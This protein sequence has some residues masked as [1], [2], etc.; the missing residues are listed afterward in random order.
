[1]EAAV[2]KL[3]PLAVMLQDL[4]SLL[5]LSGSPYAYALSIVALTYVL[6]TTFTLPAVLW[7]RGR[8][9]RLQRQVL[10]AW[11]ELKATLPQKVAVQCRR[12]GLSYEEFEVK[13]QAEV[14]MMLEGTAGSQ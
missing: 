8:N 12:A 11:Q 9:D 14:S 5:H 4:P 1:M 2:A 3:E 10:P 6:R 13:M 7:Q